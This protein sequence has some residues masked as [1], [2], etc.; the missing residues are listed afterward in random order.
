MTSEKMQVIGDLVSFARQKPINELKKLDFTE[1]KKQQNFCS[2]KD[3][4]KRMRIQAT[5]W[6]KMFAKDI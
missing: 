5:G 4:V 3:N 2:V 6:E 1:K